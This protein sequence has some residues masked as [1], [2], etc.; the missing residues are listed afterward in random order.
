M[1]GLI[2]LNPKS[3]KTNLLKHSKLIIYSSSLTL[4][5]SGCSMFPKEEPV[6]APPLI[7][8]SEINLKTEKA[9]MGT[10]VKTLNLNGY[11]APSSSTQCHFKD[12][13]GFLKKLNFEQGQEVK[14]GDI[15]AELDTDSIKS[16]IQQEEI[17]LKK[18]KL[19]YDSVAN[20]AQSTQVD[21]ENAALDVEMQELQMENLKNEL[22]KMTL[23]APLSGIITFKNNVSLGEMINAYYPLYII[24]SKSNM[25]IECSG[26]E[27]I[28][29]KLGME[30]DAEFSEFKDKG[31]VVSV[32]IK[33]GRDEDNRKVIKIPT[34][35]IKLNNPP[36]NMLFGNKAKIKVDLF[37]KENTLL[38]PK[39]AVKY[40]D[41]TPYVKVMDNG[42]KVEKF[43]TL[44][45]ENAN[46]VEI[47]EGLKEGEEVII[48]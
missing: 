35:Q 17:K 43:V 16:Q 19:R 32:N 46:V 6:S 28:D 14:E 13:G 37:K 23:R 25:L 18:L 36:K 34:A 31:K 42:T 41:K 1:G 15:L 22:S 21:K 40:Y 7:K 26:D 8:S 9:T 10:I 48:N 30:V 3:K 33:E 20:N 2:M 38:I 27:V 44:G 47:T 45:I 29:V 12:R 4:L 39:S 5:L 11:F 24:S